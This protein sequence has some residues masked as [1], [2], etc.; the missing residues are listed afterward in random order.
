M[1]DVTEEHRFPCKVCGSEMRFDPD[2]GAM[3]C[4]HCGHSEPIDENPWRGGAITELDF[5]K[6][7]AS[8]MSDVEMEEVRT[9]SCPNCGAL[10]EFAENDHATECPFCATPVVI[11]T[12]TNRQIKP[13]GV[14]PFAL[15]EKQ[16]RREMEKWLGKL[17][18]APGNLK[19]Y[20]RAGRKM[21]GLYVP[22]WTYD[23]DTKSTYTGQ[24]GDAYYVTETVQ[25]DGKTETR[26]VRKIRWTPVSG[27]VSR[28][29]DDI[30]VLASKSLPKKYTDA[31]EPWD[32]AALEPYNPEYL[33]GFTAEG[34]TVTLEEGFVEARQIMDDRIRQDVRRDIG[35]DEQR[36]SRVD[37][38]VSDVTFKHILLPIWMAAYKYNGKTYRFVVN[39]RTGEVKGERPYSKL[40][41]ALATIAAVAVAAAIG[42]FVYMSK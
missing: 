14:L 41:I 32:L 8:D 2:S 27:R 36:I 24:R 6:A 22:Y 10:I 25:V 35:G 9:T 34:Y 11:G 12:G 29:F 31:L 18:F 37:T 7:L 38:Q 15:T 28:W 26:Q 3:L 19:E 40:K 20:A 23:A 5:Q 30:L 4:D 13:K 17:W 42:Y 33:A 16:A 1:T 21:A 39:A